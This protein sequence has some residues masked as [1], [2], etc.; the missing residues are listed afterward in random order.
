M[1]EKIFVRQVDQSIVRDLESSNWRSTSQTINRRIIRSSYR[2][3][4]RSFVRIFML[5]DIPGNRG[6][7]FKQP[8]LQADC[9]VII[10]LPPN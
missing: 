10:A 4:K 6:K 3:N 8:L 9:R 1:I 5:K 7:K 2:Q